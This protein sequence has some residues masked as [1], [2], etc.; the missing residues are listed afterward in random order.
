LAFVEEDSGDEKGCIRN[1]A[2]ECGE[3]NIFKSKFIRGK[4]ARLTLLPSGYYCKGG[5]GPGDLL[6]KELPLAAIVFL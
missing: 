1:S 3:G 4:K 5:A 6:E 2:A